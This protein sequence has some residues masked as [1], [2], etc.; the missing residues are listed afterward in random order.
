MS[1]K[2]VQELAI[3]VA[4]IDERLTAVCKQVEE[5][6]ALIR[7]MHRLAANTEN[8]AEQVKRQGDTMAAMFAKYD[9]KMRGMGERIGALETKPG[10]EAQKTKETVKAAIITAIICIVVTAFVTYAWANIGIH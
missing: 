6:G 7:Q 4:R 5:S 1:E 3:D 8:L 9:D 2:V 10:K